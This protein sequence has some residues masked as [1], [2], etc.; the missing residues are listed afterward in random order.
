MSNND[1]GL[2]SKSH[3]EPLDNQNWGT[4]SFIMEQY[5]I[6]NDLWDIISRIETEPTNTTEKAKFI[7]NQK[8]AWAHIA[9]HVTPSQLN[10]VHLETNPKKIWDELQ[11]LNRPR[12]FG[13]C[14]ALCQEFTK[15]KKNHDMLMSKWIML[16][17]DVAHQIKDLKGDVPDE[18]IIVTLTNS[19]PDSYTPLVVH[20]DTMDESA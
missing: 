3:I 19:L 17:C 14:M 2:L 11:R 10:A 13:T 4:W 18:E 20:L 1:T 16:V 15:M 9:L 7:R 5:L 8:S 12:G 6:M